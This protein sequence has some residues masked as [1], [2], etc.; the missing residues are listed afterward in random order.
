M[1]IDRILD[2]EVVENRYMQKVWR[3]LEAEDGGRIRAYDF[4]YIYEHSGYAQKFDKLWEKYQKV[5][6]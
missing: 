5:Y 6:K 2:R 3:K 4:V 1:G